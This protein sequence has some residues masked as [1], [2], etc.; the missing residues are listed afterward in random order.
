MLQHL[1]TRFYCAG[2]QYLKCFAVN[3]SLYLSS[4]VCTVCDVLKCINRETVSGFEFTKVKKVYIKA[5]E[6]LTVVVCEAESRR[7][8]ARLPLSR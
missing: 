1:I 2:V 8:E 7:V 5:A 3:V 6:R 4:I